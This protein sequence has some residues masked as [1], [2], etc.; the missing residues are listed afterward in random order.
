MLGCSGVFWGVL[1]CAGVCWGVLGS[2][3]CMISLFIREQRTAGAAALCDCVL[4]ALGLIMQRGCRH[5]SSQQ[6]A[7]KRNEHVH[8][9]IFVDISLSHTQVAYSGEHVVEL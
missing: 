9:H 6:P 4:Q 1:G 8:I 3:V 5:S 2:L 7:R